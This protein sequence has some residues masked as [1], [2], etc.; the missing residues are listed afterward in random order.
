MSF[1]DQVYWTV[2]QIPPG[3]VASYGQIALLVGRPGAAR[4]V[5]R[6]MSRCPYGQAVPCHRVVNSQGR[7]APGFPEQEGRLLAEGVAVRDGRVEME[8]FAWHGEG[9]SKPSIK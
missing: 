5:G 7:L 4:A 8:R 2:R 9:W 1:E 6:A 3:R